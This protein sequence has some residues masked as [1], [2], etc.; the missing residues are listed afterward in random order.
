M[1]LVAYVIIYVND[2][3]PN[4][5][6]CTTVLF[7]DDTNLLF[8]SKDLPTLIP[9]INSSLSNISKWFSSNKLSLNVNKTNYVIFHSVKQKI[10]IQYPNI[11]INGI[12]ITRVKTTKFL[13]VHMDETL[14]W[15]DHINKKANQ[16]A[17]VNSMLCKLKH[18]LPDYTLK[19]IYQ[20]LIKPHI[21]YGITAWGNVNNPEL[22]RM[23]ILQK[24]AVRQ[25]SKC[26]YISHTS[27]IFKKIKPTN[28]K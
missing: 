13:G 10:P 1:E 23:K 3:P 4:C 11:Q 14:S 12:S 15:K 2:F 28:N 16:I 20:S 24:K 26:N 9:V 5:K 19:T 21:Q 17:R 8:V 18:I 27:P 22:K 25:I 6:N 7:A